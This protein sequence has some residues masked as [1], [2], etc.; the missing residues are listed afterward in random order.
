MIAWGRANGEDF[1]FDSST[2]N[3]I[4]NASKIG[5]FNEYTNNNLAVLIVV[6]SSSVSFLLLFV[7]LIKKKKTN[8]VKGE[9]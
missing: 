1:S 5:I 4:V 8:N 2:G 7:F 9:N 3:L 6:A